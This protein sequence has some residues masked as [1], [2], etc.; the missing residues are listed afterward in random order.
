VSRALPDGISSLPDGALQVRS[1]LGE[2]GTLVLEL[3]RVAIAS[4]NDDQVVVRIEA[5]PINPSDLMLLLAG[6]DAAGARFEGT[7]ERP[8]FTAHL[9]REAV[10]ANS[11]RI[12]QSLAVGLE[13]AGC[14]VAAGKNAQALLGRRVAVLSMSAGMFGQYCTVSMD[15]CLPVPD[16]VSAWQSAGL[17]CNPLT[18]LAIVETL[19]QTG[20][21]AMVQT[22]AASNLGQM[23]VRICREDGIT[24]VNIVRRHEHVELLQSIGALYVCNSSAPTF[25]DDLL[26]A[27]RATRAAVAFDAIGGGT[28][29]SELLS[30]ME[31]AAVERLRGYAPYGS[32]EPKRVYIYG[33]LDSSPT[34]VP[35]GN[36]GLVWGIEGWAMPP[37]LEKAGAARVR[38]FTQRIVANVRTTFA[39]R[40]GREISLAQVL[41]R[42]VM[43]GYCRRA[44]AEKYLINPWLP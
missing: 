30:G 29:A 21:N 17:F 40:Y 3:A 6:A 11:S 44:T 18:A 27:L 35:K 9:S 16:E 39:S 25:R 34:I 20:R 32:S 8:K 23:L 15:E 36:Y 43:L 14:V 31:A 38:E 41:H 2:D 10:K 12:A 1:T 13:G 19:R 24:L 7:P 5:T 4:P 37:I 33:R 26:S 22:A 28:M 42:E